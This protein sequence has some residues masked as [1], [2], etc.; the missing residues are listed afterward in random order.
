MH[1][2]DG[3][4]IGSQVA[5]ALALRELGKDVQMVAADAAPPAVPGISRRARHSTSHR[6]WPGRSTRQS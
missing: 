2:P 3:D 1:G 4:A 5:M 6:R